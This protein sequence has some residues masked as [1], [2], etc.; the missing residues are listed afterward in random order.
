MK[1]DGTRPVE[2]GCIVRF[3]HPVRAKDRPWGE[4]VVA[5]WKSRKSVYVRTKEGRRL[6][7]FTRHLVVVRTPEER[8]ADALMR[9]D[10]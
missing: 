2:V 8:L 7:A 1:K 6:K 5:G 3:R 9:G 10:A 4:H